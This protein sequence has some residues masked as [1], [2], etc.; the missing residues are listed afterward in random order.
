MDAQETHQ[1]ASQRKSRRSLYERDSSISAVRVLRQR[2]ADPEGLR[3]RATLYGQRARGTEIR[4]GIKEYANWPTI[5]SSTSTESSLADPT[6]CVRCINPGSCRSFSPEK[7]PPLSGR[8]LGL[9]HLR[10][11]ALDHPLGLRR[12][13]AAEQIRVVEYVVQVVQRFSDRITWG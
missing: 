5:P 4:Q 9:S 12:V 8:L 11:E 1:A 10:K 7:K 2:R 3:G 13:A 6:S